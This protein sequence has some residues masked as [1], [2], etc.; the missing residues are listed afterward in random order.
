MNEGENVEISVYEYFVKHCGIE[1]TYSKDMPCL[2]VGKPKRPTYVPIEVFTFVMLIYM[3]LVYIFGTPLS[4]ISNFLFPLLSCGFS[5]V[6][7]FHYKGIRK[8][9]LHCREHPWWKNQGR[10]LRRE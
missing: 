6:H 2:D 3:V 1:L 5:Y 8:H 9:C 7:L 4:E 10:S